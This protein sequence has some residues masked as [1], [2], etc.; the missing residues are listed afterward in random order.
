MPAA[1]HAGERG[2]VTA[3]SLLIRPCLPKYQPQEVLAGYR[4]R[5]ADNFVVG[6]NSLSGSY[7]VETYPLNGHHRR[8][9]GEHYTKYLLAFVAMDFSHVALLVSKE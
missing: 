2:D 7:S 6:H 8:Q 9:P 5:L 1:N 4:S 3:K